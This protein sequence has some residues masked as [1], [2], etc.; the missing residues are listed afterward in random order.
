LILKQ[1]ERIDALSKVWLFEHCSRK[2]LSLLASNATPLHLPAGKVLA[3]E[4]DVGREFFIITAGKAK[5][6]RNGALI[7][8]LGA[9]SFFG[10]M[11]LLE[12]APRVATVTALEAVDVLVLTVQAFNG[13]V[14][15]MPS[16]DR[17]MLTVLAT[18][19]R[20]LETR[21]LPSEERLF[22]AI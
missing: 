11:A 20:D 18:R 10:E 9:G 3:R 22:D 14:S 15:T 21:F 13:V 2:E 7:A 19:I 16:V 5:A 4:G 1:H 17:K 8:T 12:S 6:T